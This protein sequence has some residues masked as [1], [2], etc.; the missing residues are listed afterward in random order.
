M[1]IPRRYKLLGKLIYSVQG[2][3]IIIF[4]YSQLI[5]RKKNLSTDIICAKA[6]NF[7][8]LPPLNPPLSLLYDV[9]HLFSMHLRTHECIAAPLALT[10][11]KVAL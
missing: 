10:N 4:S 3:I 6:L 7:R 1:A 8:L 2:I 5:V 11:T 9:L